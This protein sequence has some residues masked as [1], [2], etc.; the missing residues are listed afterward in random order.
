MLQFLLTPSTRYSAGELAQMVIEGG[1]S[2]IELHFPE[3]TD[4]ELRQL[5][6]DEGLV[7]LCRENSVILTLTDRPGLA[8]ELGIHGVLLSGA[9]CSAPA[10]APGAV[11]NELGPE[12]II[13]AEITSADAVAPLEGL[14]IDYVLL[15]PALSPEG[16][17]ELVRQVRAAGSSFP[18]VLQGEYTPRDCPILRQAG[19]S[20]LLVGSGI[21]DAEDPVLRTAEYLSALKG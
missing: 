13:G 18:I 10:T 5:V 14:D 20:G 7:E 12:A 6:V 17:L 21:S 1:C 9:L 11:R 19:V 4:E 16:R 15:S 3:L 8:R 2:W